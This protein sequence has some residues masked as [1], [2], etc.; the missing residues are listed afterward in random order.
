MFP[1]G[2]NREKRATDPMTRP[3]QSLGGPTPGLGTLKPRT[4]RE[5]AGHPAPWAAGHAASHDH[6]LPARSYDEPIL[7]ATLAPDFAAGSLFEPAFAFLC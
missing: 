7:D 6:V 5:T 4:A 1:E 2:L 3:L